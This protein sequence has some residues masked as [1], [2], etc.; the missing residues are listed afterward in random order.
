[1]E[2]TS[3]LPEIDDSEVHLEKGKTKKPPKARTSAKKGG[4]AKGKGADRPSGRPSKKQIVESVDGNSAI[5]KAPEKS[6]V[7]PSFIV[8]DE[9]SNLLPTGQKDIVAADAGAAKSSNSQ[10]GSSLVRL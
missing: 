1:V 10:L 4:Q 5:E 2:E 3:A 6:L 9:R 8:H 7:S